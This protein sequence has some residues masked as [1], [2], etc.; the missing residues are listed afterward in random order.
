LWVA[1]NELG[2]DKAKDAL[3]AGDTWV[4]LRLQGTVTLYRI[5][6]ALLNPKTAIEDYY[7]RHVGSSVGKRKTSFLRPS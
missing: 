2:I 3:Q 6:I 5:T 4:Q 1:P 7:R